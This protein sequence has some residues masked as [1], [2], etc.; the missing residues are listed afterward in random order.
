MKPQD[1]RIS[2]RMEQINLSAVVPQLDGIRRMEDKKGGYKGK[3][4]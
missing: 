1:L 3:A 4:G 2:E